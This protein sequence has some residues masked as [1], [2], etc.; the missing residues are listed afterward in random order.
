VRKAPRACNIG[1]TGPRVCNHSVYEVVD[2]FV[3]A[4]AAIA[5]EIFVASA[6]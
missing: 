5:D 3:R 4:L 6:D 1:T 2:N